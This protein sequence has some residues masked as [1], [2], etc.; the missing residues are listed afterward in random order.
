VQNTPLYLNPG[1]GHVGVGLPNCNCPFA[2]QLGFGA[3][4]ADAWMTYSSR[5]WKTNI[6]TLEGAL[7]KV[8]KLRGVTYDLKATGKPQI[9]LIAEEVGA[10]IPE[11]VEWE[12]NGTD[13]KGVDYARLT[14]ILIEAAKQQQSQIGRLEAVVQS[15]KLQVQQVTAQLEEGRSGATAPSL[16]AAK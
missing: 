8:E 2:V 14:A 15:L 11:V 16:V 4:Y 10:V 13:A 3:A 9:G 5:R 7:E 1:G 12:E 6:R